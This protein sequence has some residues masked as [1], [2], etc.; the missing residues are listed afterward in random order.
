MP[1]ET[2]EDIERAYKQLARPNRWLVELG[3]KRWPLTK[4]NGRYI[5]KVEPPVF[6]Y[7]GSFRQGSPEGIPYWKSVEVEPAMIEAIP[8]YNLMGGKIPDS[9]M[10]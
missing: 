8:L 9:Y 7:E 10:E 4:V 5:V 6:Y 2:I 3:V 1:D